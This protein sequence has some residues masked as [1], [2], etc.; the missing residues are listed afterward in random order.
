[1]LRWPRLGWFLIAGV[2]FLVGVPVALIVPKNAVKPLPDPSTSGR[3]AVNSTDCRTADGC[4]QEGA[5]R[6]GVTSVGLPAPSGPFNFVS[7]AI[8]SSQADGTT[9][10][11]TYAA[12][13]SSIS[14]AITRHSL[15]CQQSPPRSKALTSPGGKSYCQLSPGAI[16][17]GWVQRGPIHYTLLVDPADPSL[18]ASAVDFL[19]PTG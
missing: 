12:G 17:G 7:G 16:F 11:L 3:F 6:L 13:K 5:A 4:F 8:L 19:T 10:Y 2:V 14:L 1:M 9:V 15:T 18:L